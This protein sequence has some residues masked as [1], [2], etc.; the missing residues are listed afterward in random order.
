MANSTVWQRKWQP[1][2]EPRR[3]RPKTYRQAPTHCLKFYEAA[4]I[5]SEVRTGVVKTLCGQSISVDTQECHKHEPQTSRGTTRRRD[6]EQIITK[7]IPLQNKSLTREK[8]Q[9]REF[10]L[11]NLFFVAQLTSSEPKMTT[12]KIV[13]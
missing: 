1:I 2:V 7:Q 10:I 5:A 4:V 3:A 12:D 8:V 9:A 11:P 6:D 13:A